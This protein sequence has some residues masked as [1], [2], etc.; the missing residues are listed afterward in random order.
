MYPD[1]DR[2]YVTARALRDAI[3]EVPG[4]T[5]VTIKQTLDYPTLFVNVNRERAA[6][7]GLSQRDVA[8]SMLVSLSSSAVVSP[9]YYINPENHVNYLVAV[10]VPTPQM[11]STHDL[12]NTPV[13]RFGL[14]LDQ[15]TIPARRTTD[16]V[17]H[18]PVETL[19]NIAQVTPTVVP[20]VINHYTVA[21]VLDVT[22]SVTGRDLG[23]VVTGIDQKIAG[24]GKVPAG[25]YITV[26][27]QGEVMNQAFS[28]LAL[29]FVVSILL[30]YFLMVVLFQSWIDPLIIMAAIPGAI[31]GI[32]WILVFT[33][34]T[35]NV[36]SLMG[37]IM[38]VGIG[39]SNS[40]LVVTF[41]HDLRVEKRVSAPA[42]AV[43]AGKTRLRP[44]LMTALA[45]ILGMVPTAIGIGE[46]SSQNA[47]LGRAV[48]GGLIMATVF[49]LCVVPVVY[50]LVRRPV[51]ERFSLEE[52]FK[53]EEQGL[54][55]DEGF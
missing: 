16:P 14:S 28:S 30:V 40:I 33:H 26:R 10:E 52:R 21:R 8:N 6:Q 35:I 34:T 9:T 25:M 45:M 54:A 48:I 38:A 3:S 12:M 23:S 37:S 36:V 43:E 22:A 46:G 18:A 17:P 53:A 15:H 4:A 44:V 2:A 24:L 47:P 42:A 1:L 31:V 11:T 51:P 20:N 19:D 49:T 7:L 5:D 32:L 39:V 29:G 27:G 55:Y 13:T 41:A 50:S